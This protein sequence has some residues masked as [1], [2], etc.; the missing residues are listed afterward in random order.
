MNLTFR[1]QINR[2]VRRTLGTYRPI[3]CGEKVIHVTIWGSVVFY[4]WEI[5]LIDSPLFQRL[6]DVSQVG[7]AELTYPAARHSRL[8]HSL[9]TV[10][11]ATRMMERLREQRSGAPDWVLTREDL[12]LVRLAALLHDVGHCAFSHLSEAVYRTLPAF[13]LAEQEVTAVGDVHPK[14]H[15]LLTY[16]ILTSETFG[17]FFYREISYPGKESR[18]QVKELLTQTANL[19]IGRNNFRTCGG[20]RACLSYL[21]AII[22]SDFDADKLDYTQRDSYTTGIALS[23]GVERFLLKILLCPISTPEGVDYRLAITADGLTTVEE[24]LFNRC[25]LYHYMY[26]HQ[27]VLATEAQMRDALF[28]LVQTGDF[29]HPC[30]FL[31][32]TD[33]DIPARLRSRKTPFQEDEN[34]PRTLASLQDAFIRRSLPKRCLELTADSFFQKEEEELLQT[35]RTANLQEQTLAI[36]QMLHCRDSL[37]TQA[38]NFLHQLNGFSF[39]EYNNL[40]KHLRDAVAEEY[41]TE[42]RHGQFDLYDFHIVMLPPIRQNLKLTVANRDGQPTDATP[43]LHRLEE[44]LNIFN[45][46]KWRGYVFVSARVDRELAGRGA[47]R[48]LAPMLG[49]LID[50]NL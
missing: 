31:N 36:E 15:E 20:E 40:R 1:E 30:D 39:S 26:R 46:S 42:G 32:C 4:G 28:A 18:Q 22:N 11:I 43:A 29:Q 9:G 50:D 34:P 12:Y 35:L 19:V 37:P 48:A 23:Y 3:S 16:Y 14:P 25:M 24:L 38:M 41:R 49:H 33:R 8:E 17:D 47:R 27:K 45:L 5:Q 2:F 6:R 13:P 7:M 10:A 44:W 21:T